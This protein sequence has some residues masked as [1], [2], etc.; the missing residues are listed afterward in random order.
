MKAKLFA[1]VGALMLVVVPMTAESQA[2]RA[3]VKEHHLE[4]SKGVRLT[5]PA[6]WSLSE[7]RFRNAL[8]LVR[9]SAE[10]G[11]P[12]AARVLITTEQR[13]SHAEAVQRLREIAAEI[14]ERAQFMTIGGWP[15]LQR[16]YLAP[17]ERRGKRAGEGE[18]EM[19][20]RV[21]TAIAAADLLL[22]LDAVVVPGAD[23]KLADEA[24]SI[25]RTAVFPWNA[26]EKQ[27]SDEL[28]LLREQALP[29]VPVS[30]APE[31]APFPVPLGGTMTTGEPLRSA[32]GAPVLAR[33]GSEIEVAASNDGQNV[34]VANNSGWAFSNNGGSTF[35]AIAGTPGTFPRDGDPSVAFGL[36]GSFYYGF[37]GFPNGTPAAGG[38]SGCSTS[39]AASTDNG[40]TF[41]FRAHAVLCPQTGAGICF[42][43]QE[44][45]AADRV[46]AAPGGGDQVYSVWRN[47]LPSGTPPNCS[48]I[49]SGFPT[50]SIVCSQDNGINWTP[51]AVVA[52]AGDFP[53]VAIGA[54]GAVYVVYRQG[55]NLM[56]NRFSSCGAGLVQQAGYPVTV[57]AF[58]AVAC[59]VPGL[60]RCNDG[61][62]LTSPTVAED[63][64]N[65][66]HVY[67]A[68]ATNTAAG[69]E[70]VVV[71]D[72][73]D[74]GLT[75]PRSVVVNDPGLPA[76]RYMPWL[77]AQNGLA[78]VGWYD[79]RAASAANNDLTDYYLGSAYVEG[80]VLTRGTELNVSI[81]ADPECAT[82]WP[83]G[84]RARTDSQSCSAQPQLA[85]RCLN[86]TGGGSATA[87]DFSTTPSPCPTGETCQTSSG[88][89][90]YG[91]YNGIAC[92][93]NRVYAAWASATAPPGLAT[94]AAITSFTSTLALADF[95]VRDWT[96][97]PVSGDNGAQPSIH[98]VFYATSDV[99]N[100][101]ST[102]P[103]PF[104]NDQPENEDAGNGAGNVGDNWAFARIRRNASPSS[105]SNTVRAHF[106]V[107]KL[108]TGSN[109]VDAGSADPDVTFLDPDPTVAFNAG[110]LGPVITTPYHWHLA[111]VNSTHLCL[112]VEI[113]APGD[114][115]IAPS[116]VG[117]APGWPVTDTKIINDNNKAQRNMG[118]STTPATG[119][120]ASLSFYGIAHNAATF[121]RDMVLRVETSRETLDRFRDA[122]I[123]IVGGKARTLQG[124]TT[125]VLKGMAPGENRWVGLTYD[126]PKGK[127][128]ETV[129]AHFY[130]LERGRPVNGFAIGARPASMSRVLHDVL[131]LHRSVFTR[132]AE[133]FGLETARK[134]AEYAARLLAHD[135][136]TEG[137]YRDFARSRQKAWR[138]PVRKLLAKHG[139]ED[140]FALGA[141]LKGVL[142]SAKRI[143]SFAVMHTNFLNKLDAYITMLQLRKGDE[144]DI[145]Q[146]VRWQRDL[147]SG[148]LPKIKSLACS[149]KVL[150]D[151]ARYI[152][153]YS[154][155][156]AGNRD[157]PKLIKT[158]LPCLLEAVKALNV[159]FDPKSM[160][161][162]F[163]S[164]TTLQKAHR[165]LLLSLQRRVK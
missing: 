165:E 89:P 143:D 138:D 66:N 101:R 80:G 88:C 27:V 21:T 7:I 51:P 47:F 154:Q 73:T 159:D 164:P 32:V 119:T 77:C 26:D 37:I 109:Y 10:A 79:R 121:P 85:G 150:D 8:E 160:E 157:Y 83:C 102:L 100:R 36:G 28:K 93:S 4:V 31:P 43:D 133:G 149:E 34:V 72:S 61:N 128:G 94:V 142:A 1:L 62:I 111:S 38:V 33:A 91:D 118:L 125:I 97:S 107:S 64:T 152:E 84:A 42:P 69:N 86:A 2:D 78:F 104:V 13:R 24:L 75:W 90:K 134:D 112:A 16:R 162:A 110:N 95:Y 141:A 113:S 114:P 74:G 151:S 67:M 11:A 115:F 144:A 15:A 60:D 146:N 129:V 44:H 9:P 148:R 108:G 30:A 50:A 105:G 106:L 25:G 49:R 132:L 19:A 96:D 22:R 45:I 117:Y 20:W 81:N 99:W 135:K 65:P 98:P 59:P 52:A 161:S 46:N 92:A 155:R 55:G 14:A 103:G 126:P 5:Y 23:P 6:V 116:L 48:S 139:G 163:S 130:E 153:A 145:L 53:R 12:P 124:E 54:S 122:R 41:P 127:E 35:V 18:A 136:I 56:L 158:Q 29:R 131:A 82:G 57:A 120:G 70:N 137:V 58:N 63:D 76:R 140:P 68:V 3:V 156:Q 39:I 87:C 40:A 71:Y 123:E 147:F 17:V